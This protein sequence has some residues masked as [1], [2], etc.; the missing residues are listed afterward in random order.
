MT[1]PSNAA[2]GGPAPRTGGERRNRRPRSLIVSFFGAHGRRIGGWVSVSG[3]IGLMGG[4][5][6]DPP[7]VRS[8]V[9]RLKRRGLVEAERRGGAAGYRL[10]EEGVRIL[11]DGDRRIFDRR[12][13]DLA[14]GWVLVVF[15]IPESE[16]GKR[17]LLRTRLAWLG[18]GST[19]AGVWIA[20]AHLAGEA[21][22]ALG[23][24]G[25]S[26]YA[27]LFSGHR[28]GFGELSDAVADW[29]DLDALQEMY[30]GFLDEYEP[31]LARWRALL[32]GGRGGSA[33]EWPQG[34]EADA[35]SAFADHLRAVDAWRR[36]PFLDPGLPPEVLPAE[37]SGV[38]AG[39]VFADLHALLRE[40][41]LRHVEDVA[42]PF[43]DPGVPGA[44][45]CGG[46]Q[47]EPGSDPSEDPD[48]ASSGTTAMPTSSTRA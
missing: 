23:E 21:R 40:P 41:A 9:S 37:W 10:S 18:F 30:Q 22:R 19:A 44:A 46:G 1:T 5:D 2:E 29:W 8:A 17:H 45:P 6:V 15:S 3:L 35:P 33:R 36:M 24:L 42:G 28:I 11:A 16:R 27:Q 4:L 7:A 20:P 48:G 12:P 47:P 26:E 32:H 14:D 31:V 39:R 34:R 43:P 25:V 13:A 38:R